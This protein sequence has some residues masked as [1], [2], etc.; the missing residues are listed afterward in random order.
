MMRVDELF[1]IMRVDC[2][3]YKESCDF[4]FHDESR[5]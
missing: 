1:G 2:N 3:D 5:G 4:L